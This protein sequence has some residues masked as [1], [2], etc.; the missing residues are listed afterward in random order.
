MPRVGA[1]LQ[2]AECQLVHVPGE[3]VRLIGRV[4][5]AQ[6]DVKVGDPVECGLDA[7]GEKRFVEPQG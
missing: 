2:R 7:G 4:D 6:V 3:H 1:G 5:L